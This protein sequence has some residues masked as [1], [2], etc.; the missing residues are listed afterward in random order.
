MLFASLLG[1][2]GEVDTATK[3]AACEDS[4][5]RTFITVGDVSVGVRSVTAV[6]DPDTGLI[7]IVVSEAEN[8]CEEW[9]AWDDSRGRVPLLVAAF[10]ESDLAALPTTLKIES[11]F[12]P[13]RSTATVRL[14]EE[15]RGRVGGQTGVAGTLSVT[16]IRV[17]DRAA[18]AIDAVLEDGSKLRLPFD[19]CFCSTAAECQTTL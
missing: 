4:P 15:C 2:G 14:A 11:H 16:E 10:N 18:G 13:P 3:P 1:C 12:L 8:A 5:A 9:L 19:T 6:Q 17:G 7:A